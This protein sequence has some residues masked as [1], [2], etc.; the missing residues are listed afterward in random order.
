MKKFLLILLSL[1]LLAACQPTPE[2]DAVKQKDTVQMVETVLDAKENA[3]ADDFAAPVK[4]QMPVALVWDYCTERQ[5]AH[6]VADVPITILSDGGF[7]L[8]RVERRQM[9]P[10]ENLALAKAFLGTDTVYRLLPQEM[11]KESIAKEIA[12]L[13]DRLTD[14]STDNPAWEGFVQEEID[15]FAADIPTRLEELKKLYNET[16][17]G[18]ALDNPV[19]DGTIGDTGGVC[20]AP[21]DHNAMVCDLMN[22]SAG[23]AGSPYFW[24]AEYSRK[25]N[26]AVGWNYNVKERIDPSR[27]D[28][29][30]EGVAITPRKAIET[31]Q[32]LMDPFVKTRVTDV[33]WDSDE[34]DIPKPE[35]RVRHAYTVH[36]MPLYYGDAS[37][38]YLDTWTQSDETGSFIYTWQ[39]EQISVT[40]NDEGV[41][42]FEWNSPLAVTEVISENCPL[43]PFEKIEEIAKQ[44]IDRISAR[45]DF[46][47]TTLTIRSV[48]LGLVRIA[49]PYEM[50]RALLTPVWCF[51][52]EWVRDDNPDV[53]MTSAGLLWP[54]LE[55]NAIDGTVIDPENGY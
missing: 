4:E 33:F 23:R 46:Q 24:S 29:T 37:G 16:D 18:D 54:V 10:G 50:E 51:F 38:A 14:P 26:H 2:E 5:G 34:A 8:L 3:S 1:V 48:T 19:W 9:K 32:N 6:V 42:H 53:H 15:E 13:M 30:R 49:E 44:Q 28:E 39:R 43:L 41:L 22:F 36:L 21:A 45:D 27:Y 40:V 25:G 12:L 35:D 31:A 47:N 7:P 55:I 20:S 11:T 52:G 17:E